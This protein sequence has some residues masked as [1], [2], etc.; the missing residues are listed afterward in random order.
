MTTIKEIAKLAGVSRGTVDRVLNNRGDVK[1]ETA[2]RVQSIA[3]KF[4][5]SPNLVGKAL[6]MSKKFLKFGYI[7]FSST[8][9]NPFFLDVVQGIEH[10]AGELLKYN[11]T[12]EIRHAEIDNYDLQ[13]ALIDEL[14]EEGIDGLAITPVNHPAVAARLQELIRSSIPVVTANSD[15]PDCGRL[16]YV[17][18]DGFKSGQTAAG[19]VNLITGGTA[20]VG[21]ILGNP[22]VHSHAQRLEGFAR[23]IEGYYPGLTIIDTAANFDDDF[24]SYAVTQ[25]LLQDHPEINVLYLATGGIAGACCAAKDMG[26][27]D[28]LQLICHDATT[29]ARKL[30]ENGSIA[31]TITQDPFSQGEKPLDI[32]LNYVGMGIEPETDHFYT[33]IE[34]K[35][36]ENI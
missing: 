27:L 13:V 19:L 21:I 33:E 18:S 14:V 29:T 16:A 8:T 3:K 5:Y 23:Q 1:R 20:C 32:L 24:K 4:N 34:I 17:G 10:K 31:A 15:L 12:V 11:V 36:K 2:E 30:I 26:C 6:V 25:K 7:L 28:K 22:L 9:S 35:I